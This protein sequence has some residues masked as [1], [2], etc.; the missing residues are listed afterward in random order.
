V[1]ILLLLG[2][3]PASCKTAKRGEKYYE[4]QQKKND[5][6]AQK[7]YDDK[8]KEF[9]QI[10]TKNTRKMMKDL[11]KQSKQLNKSRKR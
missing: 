11:D 10:Q 3:C 4:K 5:A 6:A 2:I 9:E 7:A 1:A 8:L